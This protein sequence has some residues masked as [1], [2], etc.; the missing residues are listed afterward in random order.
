MLVND[1]RLLRLYIPLFLIHV[2]VISY[3]YKLQSTFQCFINLF[4]LRELLVFKLIY[5][6]VLFL[7]MKEPLLLLSL[8]QLTKKP[9]Q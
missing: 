2:H 7:F 5:F 3:T 6:F 4:F 8:A 1:E 9:V